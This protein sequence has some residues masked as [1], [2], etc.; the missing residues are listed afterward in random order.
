MSELKVR[1]LCAFDKLE[2]KLSPQK[3]VTTKPVIV[4]TEKKVKLYEGGSI[5]TV[6]VI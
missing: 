6:L 4:V 2:K 1:I 5:T 3:Q